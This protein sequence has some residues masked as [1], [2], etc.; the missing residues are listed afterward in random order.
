MMVTAVDWA[1][2]AFALVVSLYL[3]KRFAGLTWTQLTVVVVSC[4]GYVLHEAWEGGYVGGSSHR[5]V[6]REIVAL[7]TSVW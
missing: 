7:L 3:G 6:E 4:G 5:W 1:L 2:D